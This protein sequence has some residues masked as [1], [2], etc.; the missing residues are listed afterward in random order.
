MFTIARI[1]VLLI[2][3]R[4]VFVKHATLIDKC[5]K[6]RRKVEK[7][8]KYIFLIVYMSAIKGDFGYLEF[9]LLCLPSNFLMTFRTSS[10]NYL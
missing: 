7:P 10:E 3:Q 5:K 4:K 8:E 6:K 1:E 9:I 2:T